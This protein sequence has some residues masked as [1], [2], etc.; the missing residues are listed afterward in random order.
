VAAKAQHGEKPAALFCFLNKHF[1][2]ILRKGNAS[3]DN[4]ALKW[5]AEAMN[6]DEIHRP[7]GN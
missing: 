3:L 5:S 2:L 6:S 1:Q 7:N 4:A